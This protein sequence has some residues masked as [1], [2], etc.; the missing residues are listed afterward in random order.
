MTYRNRS[1]GDD[2]RSWGG[3]SIT[4]QNGRFAAM[5]SL[6]PEFSRRPFLIPPGAGV[7]ARASGQ[8]DAIVRLPTPSDQ[9]EVA[10]AVVSRDYRLVQHKALIACIGD[11]LK[12]AKIDAAAFETKLTLTTNGER[13]AL[14][15]LMPDEDRFAYSIGEDD[16]MRFRLECFN[17]VDGSMTFMMAMGWLRS[18]CSNGLVVGKALAHVRRSHT[19]GLD[20]TYVS[21]AIRRGLSKTKTD[22]VYWDALQSSRVELEALRDWIDGPLRKH[23]GVKAA[24]RTFAICRTGYDVELTDPFESAPPSERSATRGKKVPGAPLWAANAFNVAQ[25]L[26]WIAGQRRDLSASVTRIRD[27]PN[28]VNVLVEKLNKRQN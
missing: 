18:V 13:M 10:I 28:M 4:V 5:R 2:E 17:S 24:A 11:A 6:V 14:S 3:L 25:A 16:S 9:S 15:V 22:R 20:L 27:I 19:P 1:H 8:L 23:W 7:A 12:N 21:A 26:S